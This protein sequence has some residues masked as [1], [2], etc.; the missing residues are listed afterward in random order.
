MAE[1][2]DLHFR[3]RQLL[4]INVG[5]QDSAFGDRLCRVDRHGRSRRGDYRYFSVQGIGGLDKVGVHHDDSDWDRWTEAYPRRLMLHLVCQQALRQEVVDRI[6]AGDDVVLQQ[7]SIWSVVIGHADNAKLSQL[8]ALPAQVYVLREWLVVNG[9]D[10]SQMLSAVNCIDY[11]GL[12][13]LT[14]KNPVIHTW[15]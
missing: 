7:G 9:I 6:A 10:S 8:F 15:C 4:P 2:G 13:E 1:C 11:P 3:R 5:D 12:V 14:V